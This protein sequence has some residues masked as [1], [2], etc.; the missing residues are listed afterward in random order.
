MKTAMRTRRSE[1]T[2]GPSRLDEICEEVKDIAKNDTDPRLEAFV[3]RLML[4]AKRAMGDKLRRGE[5]MNAAT[6]S[7][8]FQAPLALLPSA[9]LTEIAERENPWAEA[10]RRGVVEL[11]KLLNEKG[12]TLSVSE[13]AKRKRVTP[14]AIHQ[15]RNRGQLIA[16]DIGQKEMR[17]PVW[18]FGSNWRLLDG[19]A[20]VLVELKKKEFEPL[21]FM[22]FFLNPSAFLGG[23]TPIDALTDGKKERVLQL[24]AL[25]DEH[26]AL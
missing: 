8:D 9:V 20:E 4:S 14:Q 11:E 16:I 23:E 13:L 21:E 3:C 17:I 18:Q 24:A 1:K 7:S 15:A 25:S 26:G 12:G 22:L 6:A 10:E 19:V 5:L 2:G